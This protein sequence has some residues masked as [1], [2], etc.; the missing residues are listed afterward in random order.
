MFSP[1]FRFEQ[2]KTLKN[3]SKKLFTSKIK[4]KEEVET[5]STVWDLKMPKLAQILESVKR[6]K[7]GKFIG[8]LFLIIV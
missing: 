8:L 4:E 2:V 3:F 7:A 6:F 5:K 1:I